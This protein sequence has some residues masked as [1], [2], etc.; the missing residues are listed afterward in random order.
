MKVRAENFLQADLLHVAVL[1]GFG[2]NL[3]GDLSWNHGDTIL[4][5]VQKVARAY[6]HPVDL[7]G[8]ANVIN[9]R[10]PMCDNQATPEVVE[11]TKAITD[12]PGPAYLRLD[13][14]SAP[15][16]IKPGET[17]EIGKARMLMDGENATLVATGG[18]VGEALKAAEML[19]AVG[20][21]CRVLSVHTIKPLDGLSLSLA[22]METGGIVTVEEHMV[23]GGL[24][25]AVAEWLLE[26]GATPGFFVRLGLQSCFS[27]VVGSQKYL[28]KV[29]GLDADSIAAAVFSR[30]QRFAVTSAPSPCGQAWREA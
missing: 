29:Y 17:F 3:G 9:A 26:A 12:L 14:S 1:A 16:T 30:F 10:P 2:C 23:E 22:A 25:G 18:I 4:I 8:R 24:G 28:R 5:T 6:L 7:H 15:P 13:K 21:T 20:V 19:E 27:S 11:A